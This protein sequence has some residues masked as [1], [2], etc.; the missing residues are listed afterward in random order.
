MKWAL[1]QLWTGFW[2]EWSISNRVVLLR[3]LLL[4]LLL[5]VVLLLMMFSFVKFCCDNSSSVL[6]SFVFCLP[7]TMWPRVRNSE[8]LRSR[9]T[10]V[11]GMLFVH[12]A[13]IARS[14]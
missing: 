3:L 13:Q 2:K 1:A 11:P 12:P 8:R 10:P 14:G 6:L 5:V 7:R 4:V 9:H